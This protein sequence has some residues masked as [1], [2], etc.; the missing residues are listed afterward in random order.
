MVFLKKDLRWGQGWFIITLFLLFTPG[1][2]LPTITWFEK[3]Y[4]DKI[5]HAII[6]ATLAFLFIY[7][8]RKDEEEMKNLWV[9][10]VLMAC[11]TY[12]VVSEMIQELFIPHRTGDIF[13][14]LADSVG[15]L[16]I[17]FWYRYHNYE[18]LPWKVEGDTM[19]PNPEYLKNKKPL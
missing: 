8:R 1:N 12:A 7:P 17:Y 14:F 18:I 11:L 6:F 3:Y 10:I 4:C 2:E 9:F 5:V 13:D 16:I 15:A 19:K